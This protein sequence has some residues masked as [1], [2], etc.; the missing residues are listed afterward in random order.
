MAEVVPKG[1]VD[2]AEVRN[3]GI[4]SETGEN[5][6]GRNLLL[7]EEG[8]RPLRLVGNLPRPKGAGDGQQVDIPAPL[9]D[10]IGKWGD[11]DDKMC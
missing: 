2:D 1:A 3:V 8:L 7:S 11:G 9:A 5:P 10:V 6:V 4:S